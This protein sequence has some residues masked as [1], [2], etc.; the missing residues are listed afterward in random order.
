MKTNREIKMHWR[1]YDIVIPKGTRVTNQTALGI[2]PNYH[3]ID[4]LSWIDKGLPLLKHDA[5]YYGI[6]ID[7]DYIDKN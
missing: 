3:F 2:D 5:T 7:P 4:D 6:N 1:G